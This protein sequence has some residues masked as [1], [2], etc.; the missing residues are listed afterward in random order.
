MNTNK[1]H[2]TN[3]H[4][5]P[6][7]FQ[8]IRLIFATILTD[9]GS[10]LAYGADAIIAV[11]IVILYQD[12]ASGVMATLLVGAVIMAVYLVAILVYN[13]MTK[14]HVHKVLGGGAFASSLITS[15]KL[16]TPW[17]K[18]AVGR[19]G[20]L[21]SASLLSDFPAT[22]AISLIAGVEA[23]YFIPMEER[24]TWAFAFLIFIS[25]IQRYG[26]GNL[27]RYMI[28]PVILFYGCNMLIQFSGVYEILAEGWERPILNFENGRGS[29]A[30]WP[31]VWVAIANGSTLLTGVE[32][33]YSS[34]N[35]PYY[36]G[37]SIRI[38]MWI[39]Y[40][41]VFI[42]YS[43]QLIN[44]LG[45]GID[46]GI[47][48][49]GGIPPVPIQIAQHIG[50]DFVAFPFGLLTAIMLLLAAQS[51]QSDFPLEMLRAS[52]S[53]FFPKGIG[54]TSWRRVKPAIKIEGHENVYN[55]RAIILLGLLS[56][57]I[58]Y[59]FPHSHDIENMYGLA[60]V[61]AMCVD[62][63]SYFLRQLRTRKFSILTIVGLFVMLSILF[64]IVYNKF[65]EG[66][67]FIVLLIA[68]Y[69][70]VFSFSQVLY[71]LWKKKINII[72]LGLGLWYPAF[73]AATVD[74]KNILL[75]SQFHPGV[76][77]FLK[78]YVESSR[79]PLVVHFQT[80]PNEAIPEEL[81]PW[82]ENVQVNERTDTVS[83]IIS[84]IAK[85]QP[86]RVHLVPLVING[87]DAIKHYY[88]GNSI[89]ALKNAL[90]ERA[91]LQVEYNRERINLTVREILDYMF[92]IL[93]KLTRK[94]KGTAKRK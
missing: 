9:P 1:I 7:L 66:A 94:K 91:D 13:S 24:L 70:G 89:E 15:E 37:Q 76:I 82:F 61:T 59:F 17:M 77:H 86:E 53:D 25:V 56:L 43:L 51:A 30:F 8:D 32:I 49:N 47:Y 78:S 23:L 18:K 39:L 22:Q 73:S 93:K 48:T 67:W 16:H 45:L 57:I 38:S 69:L 28:Y 14:H 83:A 58:L 40:V 88:F 60:V 41:I 54:D 4:S 3:N 33:G 84:Y 5:K 90:S 74:R 19:L 65:F 79:I 71:E 81:P 63:G 72:P 42:N 46:Q 11:T 10:S 92:P 21:G 12:Y 2:K 80:D 6:S 29:A 75:V 87:I 36:K 34:I 26:L 35:F 62:I 68:I 64:N 44:F 50:G 20:K 85:H 55:P 27:A 31:I 52:R